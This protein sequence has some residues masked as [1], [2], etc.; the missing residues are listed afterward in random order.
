[1]QFSASIARPAVR[2]PGTASKASNSSIA[3]GSRGCPVM[4]MAP[5]AAVRREAGSCGEVGGSA[6]CG[7]ERG[8]VGA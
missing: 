4:A 3:R 1:M 7:L 2:R 5:M 6:G 8:Q